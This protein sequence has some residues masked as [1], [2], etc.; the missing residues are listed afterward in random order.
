MKSADI[1]STIANIEEYQVT[2][3]QRYNNGSDKNN[4]LQVVC[5]LPIQNAEQV[6]VWSSSDGSA[7]I[8]NASIEGDPKY[9][10]P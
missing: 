2:I 6:C 8:S 3:L 1:Y 9:N 7:A 4:L 10:I 5:N